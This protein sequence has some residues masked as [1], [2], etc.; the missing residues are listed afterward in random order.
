MKDIENTIAQQFGEVEAQTD[1]IVSWHA[2][3]YNKTIF[4]VGNLNKEG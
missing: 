4:R 3:K 1:F 2:K